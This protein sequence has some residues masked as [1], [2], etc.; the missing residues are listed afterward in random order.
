MKKLLCYLIDDDQDDIDFLSMALRNIDE[1]I[2][3]MPFE[4]CKSAMDNYNPDK[5][6]P[7]YIFLDLN[8]PQVDGLECLTKIKQSS[9][10]SK[11]PVIIYSTSMGYK[12]FQSTKEKGAS[13]FFVKP[14]NINFLIEKLCDL[15]YDRLSGFVIS[16]VATY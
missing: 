6:P 12:D 13:Y 1:S 2:E 9:Q 14:T 16:Q 8:M 10:F 4:S 5:N 15:F 7:D 3:I 11:I